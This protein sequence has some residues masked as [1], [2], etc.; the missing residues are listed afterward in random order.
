MTA[1]VKVLQGQLSQSQL[2]IKY[3]TQLQ[4]IKPPN[5]SNAPPNGG[6][7]TDRLVALTAKLEAV[8][9]IHAAASTMQKM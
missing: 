9:L 8:K 7:I 4:Q 3:A 6:S 2:Y 5:G 1:E